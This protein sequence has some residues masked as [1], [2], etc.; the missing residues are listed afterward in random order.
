MSTCQQS[1]DAVKGISFTHS[2]SCPGLEVV[3]MALAHM[4]LDITWSHGLTS[5]KGK[6]GNVV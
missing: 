6:L 3:H 4:L 2:L 1:S 5:L